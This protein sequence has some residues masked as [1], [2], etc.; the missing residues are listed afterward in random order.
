[1]NKKRLYILNLIVF[2]FLSI[3]V[4]RAQENT[5]VFNSSGTES[6]F[7]DFKFISSFAEPITS[8]G[9][10]VENGFLALKEYTSDVPEIEFS[11]FPNPA[12][13]ELN[14]VVGASSN[15]LI[16]NNLGQIVVER[17]L[18]NYGNVIDV[19]H[20]STGVYFITIVNPFLSVKGYKIVKL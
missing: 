17:N 13:N 9:D 12:S 5:F 14:I 3:S 18:N 4:A 8:I 15:L 7:E 19:S 16:H 10:N 20:L 11:L 1:M 6:N 2:L